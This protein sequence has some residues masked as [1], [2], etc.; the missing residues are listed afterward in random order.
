VSWLSTES[1]KTKDKTFANTSS[2]DELTQQIMTFLTTASE[3]LKEITKNAT[4]TFSTDFENY[5]THL[6]EKDA[7]AENKAILNDI[8]IL[9]ASA[10]KKQ[11]SGETST[12][13]TFKRQVKSLM[14]EHGISAENI[15]VYREKRKKALIDLGAVLDN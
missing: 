15:E 3:N 1:Q 4:N 11:E 2:P 14:N 12:A 7:Q 10:E 5:I 9:L 6:Q 13:D 8:C